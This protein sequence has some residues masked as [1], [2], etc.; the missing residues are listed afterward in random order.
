M[1]LIGTRIF[2]KFPTAILFG[3]FTFESL[4]KAV[5]HADALFVSRTV[6][7]RSFFNGNP[8]VVRLA[9]E[10]ER[11][12]QA[13]DDASQMAV[14]GLTLELLTAMLRASR[15]QPRSRPPSWLARVIDLLH[16]SH[17]QRLGLRDVASEVDVHPT[18]LAR[19][20]RRHLGCSLGEYTRR[21]RVDLAARE[22]RDT[23]RSLAVIAARAGFHDQ[24][25][26]SRCFK[27]QTGRT[28]SEYR[29]SH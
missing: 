11:E 13:T 19:I 21:L 27:R 29:L 22:L 16:A 15:Q 12:F 9:A 8:S 1:G 23:D 20:F 3:Q 17:W 5:Q 28:P 4:L 18:H 24:S 25:H 6:P 26:F 7:D 2:L 10:L 14:E